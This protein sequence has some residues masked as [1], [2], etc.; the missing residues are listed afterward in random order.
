MVG[1]RDVLIVL[2]SR[3][4]RVIFGTMLGPDRATSAAWFDE[5]I[6]RVVE[7]FLSLPVVLI[8]LLVLTTLGSS[9]PGA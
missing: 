6:S 2:R 9:T 1:A 4:C 8:G 7:A 5:V 3:R